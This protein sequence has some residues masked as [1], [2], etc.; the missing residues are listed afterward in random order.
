M[1]FS[2]I[3]KNLKWGNLTK[4]LFIFKKWDGFKDEKF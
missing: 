3:T 4:N 1:F 2:A